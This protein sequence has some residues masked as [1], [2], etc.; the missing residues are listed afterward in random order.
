MKSWSIVSIEP[1]NSSVKGSIHAL[2]DAANSVKNNKIEI[3]PML[4]SEYS[5]YVFKYTFTNF[6][7]TEFS[8]DYTVSTTTY[9]SP[10]V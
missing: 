4:L 6:L 2:L 9:E 1:D 10:F 8:S 3:P 5:R 7:N